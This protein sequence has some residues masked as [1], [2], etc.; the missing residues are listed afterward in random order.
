V[1]DEL[2][3]VTDG[4]HS[5]IQDILCH[6]TYDAALRLAV[7]CTKSSA[8]LKRYLSFDYQRTLCFMATTPFKAR[9][10]EGYS[11][12]S[13]AAYRCVPNCP[14]LSICDCI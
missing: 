14:N 10:S 2:D 8:T 13:I 4:L 1:H 5:S 12:S 9:S 11:I 3:L 6:S 7:L